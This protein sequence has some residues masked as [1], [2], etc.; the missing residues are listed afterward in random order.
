MKPQWKPKFEWNPVDAYKT[1]WKC[2]F[3]GLYM[4][5][6]IAGG[7]SVTREGKLID[8]GFYEGYSKPLVGTMEAAE[9]CAA[10]CMT[11]VE[12]SIA[13]RELLATSKDEVLM[14]IRTFALE[15][16]RALNYID[17]ESQAE[18]HR[19]D[20]KTAWE[21]YGF[22]KRILHPDY[23]MSTDSESVLK[24]CGLYGNNLMNGWMAGG[25]YLADMGFNEEP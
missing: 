6:N 21:V 8:H 17:S 1:L 16:H 7:W 12:L 19:R 4:T 14:V 18:Q 9:D 20:C 24:T 5:A 11:K 25:V 13:A 3:G 23:D 10:G 15:K 2:E 22:I